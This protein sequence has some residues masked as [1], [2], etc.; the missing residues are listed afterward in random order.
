MS[1]IATSTDAVDQIFRLLDTKPETEEKTRSTNDDDAEAEY[2]RVSAVFDHVETLTNMLHTEA[3]QIY[4]GDFT[5]LAETRAEKRRVQSGLS[6]S[7]RDLDALGVPL[8]SAERTALAERVGRLNE[9]IS[10]NMLSFEVMIDAVRRTR[11]EALRSLEKQQSDG[12]YGN[13]GRVDGPETL[14]VNGVSVKL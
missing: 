9:A 5:K 3:D 12:V 14:S 10:R 7:L 6:R 1:T 2:E 11:A 4:A 13:T 8:T